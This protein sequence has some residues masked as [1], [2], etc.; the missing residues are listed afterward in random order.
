VNII[1]ILGAYGGTDDG[2]A[3]TS[4]Q[5]SEKVTI[6]AGN[7]LNPLGYRARKIDHMFFTHS[8]YDHIV[9]LPFFIDAFFLE[10]EEPLH[11]YGI[12][13]TIDVLKKH[14]FNSAICPDFN[15]I[16][17]AGG[18]GPA[19]VFHEIE[20]GNEYA[21]DSVRMTP[22]ETNHIVK[23]VGYVIKKHGKK[24]MFT[25]DTY[26]CGKIWDILNSDET[27]TKLIIETSFPSAYEHLALASGHLTP[28]LLNEELSHLKRTDVDIYICHIKPKH[29][30]T[31]KKELRDFERTK[32]AIVLDDG[33][34]IEL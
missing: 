15:I 11:L 33:M 29:I 12:N 23:S 32:N 34:E 26:K 19:I 16:A 21:A 7:I 17:Q 30:D 4:I 22:F 10:R 5:I 31:I 2:K 13:H 27:I 8:H 28:K 3:T 14:I 25:S 1:K 6:D 20:A 18:K 9:D 24:I